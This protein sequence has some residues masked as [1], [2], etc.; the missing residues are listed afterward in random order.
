MQFFGQRFTGD[1]VNRVDSNDR[2]A[3]L[4]GRDIGGALA[5]GLTAVFLGIVMIFYDHVL[6]SIVLA[7][8]SLNL[9]MLWLVNRGLS[10]VALRLQ[11]EQGRLFSASIVGLQSIETLKATGGE[12]DFFSKWTGYHA[13]AINSEQRLAIYSQIV[14]VLPSLLLTLISVAVLGVGTVR[15]IEEHMTVGTLVAFQSLLA[16][17]SGPI[18]KLVGV[19]AKGREASADLAR[20]ED[21][22]HHQRDWR[23][24][25]GS[26]SPPDVPVAGRLSL[27]AV[28]F[29]YNPTEPPLIQDFSLDVA[30]GRWVALV[31][32]SG[33]GKSTL[34]RLVAGLYEPQSGDVRI[35]GRS[36]RDWGR[37]RLSAILAVVDQDIRLFAGTL[38]D[39]VTLWDNTVPHERLVQAIDDAGL[40]NAVQRLPGSYH[41]I[42][43]EGGSNFNSGQ[44]Q[45]LEIARALARDPA[46][47]VLD[48]ATASLD[49]ISEKR[50]LD[51]IRRRGMTCVLVAHRLSTIRDCHEIVVL[52]RGKVVERGSHLTLMKANGAYAR[53]V[54]MEGTG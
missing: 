49:A 17:F 14:D 27:H 8:V 3:G 5:G 1:L 48:E 38:H 22:L 35:D 2:V 19:V 4:L 47:L 51:A 50:I 18:Q 36:L 54:S 30:P 23:F 7:G 26:T 53:L 45:R 40:T 28:S 42:L 46:V 16:G 21:V 44:R 6:A 11:V 43:R 9:V 34:G 31:G 12:N 29:G 10:D 41:A 25:D 24:T 33:S 15:V 52:D 39:N 37:K 13:R 20:L 32:A